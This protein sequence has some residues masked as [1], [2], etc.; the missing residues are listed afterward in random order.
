[1]RENRPYG[2]EG[3]AAI[4]VPTPMGLVRTVARIKHSGS[5]ACPHRSPDQAQ[6]L[7]GLSAP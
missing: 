7:R 6:R 5:G 3:G 4:A 2:S 1:M